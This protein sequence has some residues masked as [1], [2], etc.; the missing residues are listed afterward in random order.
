VPSDSAAILVVDDSPDSL[1]LARRYL[2]ANGHGVQTASSVSAAVEVL[3]AAAIDLVVTDLRMPQA[4]GLELVRF[5]R[6][7]CRTTAVMVVTGYPS[8]PGA[9]SAVQGGA[10][11]YLAKPYAERE[12]MDAVES[13][14]TRR[15]RRLLALDEAERANVARFGMVGTSPPMQALFHT[16][17][18]VAASAAN[19]LIVGESGVGKE[20]VARGIHATSAR[21][22]APLVPVNCGAIPPELF[23]SELFGHVRG[24]FTGATSDHAG[25]F[26]ASDR[27]TLFLDEVSELTPRLQ[28]KLLRVLQDREVYAVGATRPRKVD[29]RIVAATSRDLGAMIETGT[30]RV[31]LYY[32]LGVVTLDVP[33]LRRRGD[34]VLLLARHFAARFADDHDRPPPRFS[35][36]VLRLLERYPWPGNVRE[37][38]NVMHHLVLMAEGDEVGVPDLPAHMRYSPAGEAGSCGLRN[39]ER[40]HIKSVLGSVGGNKTQAARILGIDR[41]TLRKKLEEP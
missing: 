18:K 3:R 30:F 19:A 24:A 13:A 35:D 37:L 7:N 21:R 27:G 38:E 22:D 20:L 4:S 34:D 17:T 28:V 2:T 6:E 36:D 16:M 14:L 39:V 29:V 15:R 41:K 12:L 9:V 26:Q 10:E 31:D 11:E 40:E 32:R 5:V 1:E 33:P 8:V 25:F 23:E